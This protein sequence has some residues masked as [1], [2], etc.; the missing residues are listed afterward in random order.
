MM[1]MGGTQSTLQIRIYK[2]KLLGLKQKRKSKDNFQM[3]LI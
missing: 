3:N 2:N 1:R